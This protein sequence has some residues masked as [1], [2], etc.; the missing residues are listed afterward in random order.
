MFR[1]RI[2]RNEC[3]LFTFGSEDYH[4]IWMYNMRFAIDVVWLDG[5][6][7]I[8][9]TRESLQPCKSIAGCSTYSPEKRAKY[10][11]EFHD[12]T[13]RRN[14]IKKGSKIGLTA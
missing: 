9:G 8:V 10:V 1:D 6:S 12:G 14:K 2:A 3:M 5:K 4:G 13:I 11:L 7:R